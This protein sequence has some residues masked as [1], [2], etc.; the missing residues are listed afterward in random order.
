MSELKGSGGE[1]LLR[2]VRDFADSS[3]F[4]IEE[5]LGKGYV[6]L[7]VTE[8]ERRQ[9]L[10]DIRCVED[11][12]KELIRNAQDAGARHIYVTFQKEKGRWRHITI[13]DDG[14][15]IP[16][17][18]HRK[19]FEARVTSKVK[20]VV[21]DCFGVHG[22]GMALYSTKQVAEEVR[23]VD[24]M[25][26]A[27]TIIS[28]RIDIEKLPEK[29]DQSTFPRLE[30][31]DHGKVVITGGPHNVPRILMEFSLQP[32]V[33]EVFLGSNAEILSTLYN[34]SIELRKL[35]ASGDD[36]VGKP[37]W[38]ELGRIKEGRLLYQFAHD[39]L[40]LTV[41]ERN[42]FR[43]LEYEIQPL[44]S[45]NQLLTQGGF[46]L[47]ARR[48]DLHHQPRASW[49]DHLA[50]RISQDD[51]SLISE[52]LGGIFKDVCDK[53]YLTA[54]TP[55]IKRRKNRLIISLVLNEK[56]DD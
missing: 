43:I 8:S 42:A 19:I 28:A 13:L 35:W 11:V 47:P 53:Y 21:E 39:K 22:R 41:S 48:A 3:T 26:E 24:S 30:K 32:D 27:G 36:D 4:T 23:L 49:G 37:L 16:E 44:M 31:D 18:L 52:R 2:F 51:L 55:S 46:H 14:R 56:E 25:E 7:K 33:P 12:V 6:R 10:Q 50:R 38:F 5:E 40:G 17:M 29:K 54:E 20:D 45:I 34:H 9:A 15:G 1:D